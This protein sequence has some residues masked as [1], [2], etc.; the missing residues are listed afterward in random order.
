MCDEALSPR[1]QRSSDERPYPAH[2]CSDQAGKTD[3]EGLMHSR[4]P[5]PWT[6]RAIAVAADIGADGMLPSNV[7]MDRPRGRG[8][9]DRAHIVSR[10]GESIGNPRYLPLGNHPRISLAKAPS[11]LS[12]RLSPL[13]KKLLQPSVHLPARLGT[14]IPVGA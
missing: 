14:P 4:V 6:N 2:P 7:P 8:A 12:V 13:L 3:L 1:L 11:R 10:L 9:M 5:A